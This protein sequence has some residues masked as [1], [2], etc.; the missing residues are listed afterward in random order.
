MTENFLLFE[1]YGRKN[2]IL[3]IALYVL[4]SEVKLIAKK[5]RLS[6]KLFVN[7][8]TQEEKNSSWLIQLDKLQKVRGEL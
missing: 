7:Q 6:R 4:G 1:I 3:I 2:Y 8:D 5:M